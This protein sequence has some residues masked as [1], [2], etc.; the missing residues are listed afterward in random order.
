MIKHVKK[1]IPAAVMLAAAGV[2]QA[3]A[4][5]FHGY[6]RSGIGGSSEGGEQVC[7][8]L[9]GVPGAG[10]WRLGN[11]CGSYG[12]VHLGADLANVDG[13]KF[14]YL[15]DFSY[16]AA[17]TGDS[18]PIDLQTNGNMK[19]RQNYVEVTGL[20][21]S[22][23]MNGAAVWMGKRF[24]HREDIHGNDFFYW[25]NSGNGFG[26]DNLNPG[27]GKISLAF[28][29]P[30]NQT[31]AGAPLPDSA[32][33]SIDLRWAGLPVNPNGSLEV[34]VI[35]YL[36]DDR[37]TQANKDGYLFT[38]QHTQSNFMGGFNKLAIQK[39]TDA[40][41]ANG[42]SGQFG[43]TTMGRDVERILDHFAIA[44]N[45]QFSVLFAAVYERSSVGTSADQKWTS[46]GA[47]PMF[48]WTKNFTSA[49]EVSTDTV[50]YTHSGGAAN[51]QKGKL[52]KFT[53]APLIIRPDTGPWSRPELRFFYT[54]AK[55][56]DAAN[57]AAGGQLVG[58][59][60][61]FAG[62]KSASTFGAQ[63]EAWW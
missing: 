58:G 28:I 26:V 19:L 23:L 37:N 18:Q 53:I 32:G 34:G 45:N 43:F 40:G 57:L 8:S 6:F 12:E 56:N 20:S 5:E 24:Y 36:A 42:T 31:A 61:A 47:R 10:S 11:E 22:G 13:K 30:T 29:R 27:L 62:D 2:A 15:I 55:W 21:N 14:R 59:G 38:V 35:Q 1:L 3:A 16:Y 9:P 39:G 52:N 4:P 51:G 50:D 48:H 44:P 33:N 49:I 41:G 60:A 46:L 54:K 17:N 7:F 63:V 25:D